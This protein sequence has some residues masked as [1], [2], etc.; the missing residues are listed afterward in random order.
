M[1]RHYWSQYTNVQLPFYTSTHS[2]HGS[3]IVH[4]VNNW[5]LTRLCT[6]IKGFLGRA[7]P[8]QGK[9]KKT[10]SCATT[11]QHLFSGLME[12]QGNNCPF[13]FVYKSCDS[14]SHRGFFSNTRVFQKLKLLNFRT[15]TTD[16]CT[17]TDTHAHTCA[18]VPKMLRARGSF[19]LHNASE[20][21][22]GPLTREWC[23][24]LRKTKRRF[25][26]PWKAV[27]TKAVVCHRT[28]DKATTS[29]LHRPK[30]TL[31]KRRE[32]EVIKAYHLH[33]PDIP[34]SN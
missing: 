23:A 32:E 30:L 2:T 33:F 14:S 21:G 13:L 34:K 4:A 15:H 19:T 29:L 22:C 9:C 10:N 7:V 31:R 18:S 20:R 25:S 12:H 11:K 3:K 1:S 16:F 5:E 26:I 6:G 17:N 24:P 27:K 8:L 28:D